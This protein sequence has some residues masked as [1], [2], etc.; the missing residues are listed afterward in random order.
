MTEAEIW[1]LI[2]QPVTFAITMLAFLKA[3]WKGRLLGAIAG[4]AIGFAIGFVSLWAQRSG[5]PSWTGWI[6]AAVVLAVLG[7]RSLVRR[8]DGAG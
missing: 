6:V 1:K 8:R 2:A 3:S 4:A 7:G 5:A